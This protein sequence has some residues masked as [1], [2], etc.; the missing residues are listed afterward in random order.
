LF[1]R[2]L[3]SVVSLGASRGYVEVYLLVGLK[4]DNQTGYKNL[5]IIPQTREGRT[6]MTNQRNLHI[7][8]ISGFFVVWVQNASLLGLIAGR[9][10]VLNKFILIFVLS[11]VAFLSQ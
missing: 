11:T 10:R 3:A 4:S 2:G 1:G 7:G 6:I 9:G 8:G 5:L